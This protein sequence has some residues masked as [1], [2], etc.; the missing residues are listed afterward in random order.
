VE[1]EDKTGNIARAETF[2]W[3]SG[4][5]GAAWQQSDGVVKPVA[6][7]ESY[8]PGETAHIL[9]PTPFTA[10]Y[11]VLMTVER[12]SILAVQKFV[13]STANPIIA[14]PIEPAMRPSLSLKFG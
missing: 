1:G 9:L 12:G 8:L 13:T 14:L 5:E 11:Q 6:D 10:P 7:A 3:V 2:L 4:A